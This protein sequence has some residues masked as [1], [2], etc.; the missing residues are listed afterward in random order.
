[1]EMI[2]KDGFFDRTNTLTLGDM[3]IQYR[4]VLPYKAKTWMAIDMA[5]RSLVFDE[6]RGVAFEGYTH[7]AVTIACMMEYYTD[8]DMAAYADE[9]GMYAL[10][11]LLVSHGALDILWDELSEDLYHV[12]RIYEAIRASAIRSFEH[13]LTLDHLIRKSFGFLFTGEDITETL[14]KADGVN[15]TMVELL[16]AF[17]KQQAAPDATGG[18]LLRFGK[19]EPPKR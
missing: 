9:E 4:R 6:E 17:M 10:V 7:E 15:N 19:K 13:G 11:D 18:K 2:S 12:R 8:L 5:E 16:G 1:M 3:Q 14:A